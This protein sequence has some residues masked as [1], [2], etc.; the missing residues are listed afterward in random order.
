MSKKVCK[1]CSEIVEMNEGKFNSERKFLCIKCHTLSSKYMFDDFEV[2]T[3][4][5]KIIRKPKWANKSL[6]DQIYALKDYIYFLYRDQMPGAIHKQIPKLMNQ[7]FSPVDIARAV[8]YFYVIKKNKL[9]ALSKGPLGIV[10]FVIKESQEF[11]QQ[12]NSRLETRYEQ[13]LITLR[14]NLQALEITRKE[15]ARRKN[16]FDINSL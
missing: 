6:D 3:S 15:T 13:S 12:Q 2:N 11:Y 14:S 10:P 8:E 5:N 1:Q 16:V 9:P 7:G 4:E